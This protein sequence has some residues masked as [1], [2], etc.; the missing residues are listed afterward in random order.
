M[1]QDVGMRTT[2][3]LDEDLLAQAKRHAFKTRRTF[4]QLVGEALV[5][6]IERERSKAPTRKVELVAFR[7]DGVRKGV[8]V[9]SA[10]CLL[11]Q[12]ELD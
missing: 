5:A 12:M 3:R 11:D 9:N 2:I 10:S 4:S 7:G 8:D 1:R 6:F